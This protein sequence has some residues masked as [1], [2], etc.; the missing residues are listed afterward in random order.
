ME[1]FRALGLTERTITALQKKG[2]EEPSEVQALTIPHLI[3]GTRDVIAQAQTGT[4]KTAAFSLPIIERI[5]PSAS[6]VQAI[7]LAPTRELVV[8]VMEE[9]NSLKGDRDLRVAAIY[10]GQSYERQ[11]SQLERG[12]SI[13]VGTPGRVMDHLRR[14]SLKLDKLAF[15]ILDE[16][17]EMLNMGFVDDIEEIIKQTPD[18]K[19]ILLFSATMPARIRSLAEKYCK[20]PMFLK[21]KQELTTNLTDQIYYEVHQRDKFEALC[22]IIDIEKDFYAIIF[23]RTKNEVD[24]IT[25]HLN[26]RG[27]PCDA[28][29]GDIT[30]IMRERILGKFRKKQLTVLVATDVAARGID[31]TD[32][33]HV[34]NYSLPQNAEAYTHRIGRTGRAGKE[35]T[36]ITFI[37]PSEFRKLGF[38]KK[39]TKADIR[40]EKVPHVK[41]IIKEQQKQITETIRSLTDEDDIE[42]FREWANFLLEHEEPSDL[43][44]ALLT[45]T[46]GKKLNEK[47][48]REISPVTFGNNREGGEWRDRKPSGS[49]DFNDRGDRGGGKDR[50]SL[51]AI[52]A[53]KVLTVSNAKTATVVRVMT[54]SR[55]AKVLIVLSG[56]I[57][58]AVPVITAFPVVKVLTVSNGKIATASSKKKTALIVRPV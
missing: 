32:L 44:A 1:K 36:A 14:G 25:H 5:D 43:V 23:C 39:I 42:R 15:F 28:L 20:E 12:V 11:F 47:N 9:I 33:T 52:L 38:I 53:A 18:S 37:T 30:Q 21:T 29:H 57:A 10:G 2:F 31:V 24:E 16:A 27:Y 49:R 46:F 56:K 17:D 22:R 7:I 41:D 58:T 50:D 6:G 48:Y 19:Q 26:D 8:Q 45:H 54:V 3:N 55:A 13:V 51:I 40:K 34:I 35:G 4:G